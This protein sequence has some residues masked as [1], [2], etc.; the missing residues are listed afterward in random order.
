MP[1][2]LDVGEESHPQPGAGRTLE[3][4]ESFAECKRRYEQLYGPAHLDTTYKAITVRAHRFTALMV[5]GEIADA[6]AEA[7]P[8]R[9]LP[10]F[11]LREGV[12][13]V[14]TAPPAPDDDL[15][16]CKAILYDAHVAIAGHGAELA[17]PTPGN[18]SRTWLA[19]LPVDSWLPSY[20]EV[21]ET[22]AAKT[23]RIRLPAA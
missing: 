4:G 18:E 1:P 8:R 13:V 21:V 20:R 2:Q 15:R 14:M 3:T 9:P 23:G 6:V 12:R 7:L 19:G 11:E 10:V 17:L 22:I 16:R 5:S